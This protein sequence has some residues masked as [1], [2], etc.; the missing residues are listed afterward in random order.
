MCGRFTQA[1]TW[2]E[3]VALYRLTQAA[4]N[5]QPHYNIVPTDRVDVVTMRDGKA[6][7]A[8]MR[9]ALPDH[10]HGRLDDRFG[11]EP[12]LDRVGLSAAFQPH[13]APRIG[14]AAPQL[15]GFCGRLPDCR[16]FRTKITALCRQ[17]PPIDVG[18]SANRD[19][20]RQQLRLALAQGP[21]PQILAVD[22]LV[23]ARSAS[24]TATPSAPVTS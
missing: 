9:C 14:T 2:H 10:R 11:G 15:S 23:L 17:A 13:L 12:V 4:A 19:M 16:A 8:P 5:L 6:E 22:F 18:R 3:L 7:L 21:W 24:N 1:Y 20:A